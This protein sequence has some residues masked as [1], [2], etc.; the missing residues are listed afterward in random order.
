MQTLPSLRTGIHLHEL[1]SQLLAYDPIAD[2][3]HLLDPTTAIVLRVLQGAEPTEAK[4]LQALEL[5]FDSPSATALLRLSLDELRKAELL[6]ETRAN[7]TSLDG[8]TRRGLVKKLSFA[9]VSALLI[10]AI[11][12]LA[13]STAGA[14]GSCLPVG[15]PCTATSQCCNGSNG[16]PHCHH[17]GSDPPGNFCHNT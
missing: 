14:Q 9:G 4:A 11:T 2:R 7:T 1:D 8:I 10:P 6:A 13:P 3:V 12:T 15:S 16:A 17:I 5:N